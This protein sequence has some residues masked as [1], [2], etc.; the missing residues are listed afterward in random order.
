MVKGNPFFSAIIWCCNSHWAH[1]IDVRVFAYVGCWQVCSDATE[2]PLMLILFVWIPC[3]FLTSKN[4]TNAIWLFFAYCVLYEKHNTFSHRY[5]HFPECE[6]ST[7]WFTVRWT[8][9]N[10]KR[11]NNLHLTALISLSILRLMETGRKSNAMI[12][13]NCLRIISN[14]HFCEDTSSRVHFI[15]D[16]FWSRN[17]YT[18]HVHTATRVM[19]RMWDVR[20]V[21]NVMRTPHRNCELVRTKRV[22]QFTSLYP[23]MFYVWRICERV[24]GCISPQPASEEKETCG[25]TDDEWCVVH[26]PVQGELRWLS[27]GRIW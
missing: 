18:K 14:V 19:G 3:L 11:S 22:H 10:G 5:R 21:A 13:M 9:A 27:Y 7:N 24:S 12:T 16:S 15:R 17:I 23:G 26:C 20:D 4:S 2:Q 8:A 1:A 25:V 6:H